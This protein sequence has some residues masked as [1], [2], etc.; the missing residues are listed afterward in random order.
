MGDGYGILLC[1]VC[2]PPRGYVRWML[3]ELQV[4]PLDIKTSGGGRKRAEIARVGG[5]RRVLLTVGPLKI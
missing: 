3:G 4:S 2:F 5:A 1:Q